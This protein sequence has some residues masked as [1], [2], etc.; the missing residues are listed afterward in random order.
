M[1][2]WRLLPWHHFARFTTFFIQADSLL[3]E[4]SI[5]CLAIDFEQ[6]SHIVPTHTIRMSVNSLQ[7]MREGVLIW[8]VWT[9][10]EL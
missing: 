10:S 1:F 6:H 8:P 2:D 3:L 4:M 7:D 5:E 9:E